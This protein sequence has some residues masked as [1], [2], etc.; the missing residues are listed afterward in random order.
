MLVAAARKGPR[1]KDPEPGLAWYSQSYQMALTGH[2]DVL[3]P[4]HV[5]TNEMTVWGDIHFV[6]IWRSQMDNYVEF[7]AAPYMERRKGVWRDL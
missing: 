5:L 7:F 4:W 2:W 3:G 6:R 1:P